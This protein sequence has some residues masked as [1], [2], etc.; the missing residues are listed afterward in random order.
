MTTYISILRGINVSGHRM[1]KM[2][3]LK[4]MCVD[5]SFKNI[6]TYI[7]S[8]NIVFQSKTIDSEKISMTIMTNI[9][10]LFDFD[11]PVITLTQLELETIINSNPFLKEKSKD[12]AFFHITFLSKQPELVNIEFLNQVDLKNDHYEIINKSIYL[13]C[14][15]SYSKSKLTNT[16][17]ESKLK[18]TATTINWKTINELQNIA[19]N[20]SKL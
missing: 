7:Q 9:K 12:H 1:I 17:L 2:D 18:L 15:D 4:K 10:N 14:P 19:N 5:L 3:A 16:F 13:F 8:G 20:I 11:V 6:Q